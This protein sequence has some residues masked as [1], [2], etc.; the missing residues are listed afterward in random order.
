M[1]VPATRKPSPN[2]A[3]RRGL[4]SA[5]KG[6][7]AAGMLA[8][9]VR[10]HVVAAEIG[11]SPATLR[12]WFTT[13]PELREMIDNERAGKA[14]VLEMQTTEKMLELLEGEIEAGKVKGA[15]AALKHARWLLSKL[16]PTRYGERQQIGS[17]VQVVINTNA[18]GDAS[19]T[20]P[21]T[22]RLE[23]PDRRDVQD[24]EFEAAE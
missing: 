24:A 14:A 13:R 8:S 1:T 17:A 7:K 2:P 18:L 5:A 21:T 22:I 10:Q 11:V 6:K 20:Q 12:S 15:D 23:V 19:N 16:D 9:G 4:W 3:G